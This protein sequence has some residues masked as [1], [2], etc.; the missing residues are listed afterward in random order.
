MG[1]E[2]KR[3]G[4]GDYKSHRYGFYL[5]GSAFVFA[6]AAVLFRLN[7]FVYGGLLVVVGIVVLFKAMSYAD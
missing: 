3:E 4:P 5:F 7:H 6:T 1:G 2:M